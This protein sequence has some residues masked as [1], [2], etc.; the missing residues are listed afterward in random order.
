MFLISSLSHCIKNIFK[1]QKIACENNNYLEY[2]IDDFIDNCTKFWED[3]LLLYPSDYKHKSYM[4]NIEIS[5][6]YKDILTIKDNNYVFKLNTLDLKAIQD[7]MNNKIKNI[8]TNYQIKL[9]KYNTGVYESIHLSI[10]DVFKIK[11][12]KFKLKPTAIILY[13]EEKNNKNNYELRDLLVL[14]YML[15]YDVEI[16]HYLNNNFTNLY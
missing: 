2:P 1:K 15:P 11:E 6:N 13:F 8:I 16:K 9:D 12:N 5:I 4:S 7:E 10:D 3:K 14:I